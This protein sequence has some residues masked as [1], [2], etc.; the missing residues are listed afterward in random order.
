[1]HSITL[2]HDDDPGFSNWH[3]TLDKE[4]TRCS[5]QSVTIQSNPEYLSEERDDDEW[6]AWQTTST[7]PAFTA[8]VSRIKSLSA[9]TNVKLAFT[10]KCKGVEEYYINS[11]EI[12]SIPERLHTLQTVFRAIQ[13]R[14]DEHPS[15]SRVRS[16]T[17]ENL[18]NA[19]LM[20]FT[21]SSPF[22]SVMTDLEELHLHVAVEY[23]EFGGPDQ[24][25][26]RIERVHFEPY[27]VEHWLAPVAHQLT[28][29]SLSFT[30]SWGTA[31]GTFRG[32]EPLNFPRLKTL[33]LGNFV[34][35]HHDHFNW[36]LR[37]ASLQRL[38]M[39]NC[40]L[41]SHLQATESEVAKWKIPTH[42]WQR[43]PAGSYGFDDEYDCTFTFPGTW[44]TVFDKMRSS[45]TNLREFGFSYSRGET[46]FRDSET[47]PTE[48]HKARYIAFDTGLLPSPWLEA[49][50]GAMAFGNN[51]ES[52]TKSQR[53]VNPYVHLCSLNRASDLEEV[54]GVAFAKL[55]QTVSAREAST[56][57]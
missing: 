18:Q 16:L 57:D 11:E 35:S 40:F 2:S 25:L 38:L 44:A 48:L 32:D 22:K 9:L 37:Q 54:D 31:P 46:Q 52:V 53:G 23:A 5:I 47:R 29:L 3:K 17:I 24:D 13:D 50:D 19:P 33:S 39:A 8:A 27:L 1:M 15:A 14:A 20:G 28:S 12:E 21:T 56:S 43:H 49:H 55:Q 26:E 34:A 10:D 42:D 41:A 36:V 30:E 51:L 4:A 45:L 7:R 6:D